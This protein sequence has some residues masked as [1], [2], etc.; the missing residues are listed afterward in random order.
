M[1]RV[2]YPNARRRLTAINRR[3][4][5]A[6]GSPFAALGNKADPL[7]EAIYIILSFQ[8][9]VPR[10]MATW[11]RLRA[12]FRSWDNV[13]RSRLTEVAAV[14]RDGGLHRQKARTIKSLL[15]KVR[16]LN[17]ALSLDFLYSLADADAERIL[18]RLPG[19]SWKGA[20]CVLLYSLDRDVF[21]VDSNTFR[22]LKRVGVLRR[23]AV[24]RRRE[25]HDSLQTS[26]A[27]KHRRS[28]HVNL[29]I[30]G[31]R[32]CLPLRPRC[33]SCVLRDM[34]PQIG[35][36]HTRDSSPIPLRSTPAMRR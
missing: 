21:P 14:I 13:E 18:T 36:T 2:L 12:H 22:I 32:T 4:A 25:L 5:R 15:R 34:C 35:V 8:T 1:S 24:Y 31:Q 7:D 26:V 3:L 17:N 10:A 20:R 11:T 9:D 27:P 23:T 16:E 29:V 6:Y 33:R 30:H 28:L 19:L